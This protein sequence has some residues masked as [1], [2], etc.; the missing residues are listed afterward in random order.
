MKNDLWLTLEVC[1]ENEIINL[2][3]PEIKNIIIAMKNSTEK[4]QNK[5][6]L[7]N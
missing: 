7:K 2:E 1:E 6:W 5:I 4:L 3:A